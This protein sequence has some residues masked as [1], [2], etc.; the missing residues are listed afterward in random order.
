M[1]RVNPS[2]KQKNKPFKGTNKSKKKAMIKAKP[3]RGRAGKNKP[4]H[5]TSKI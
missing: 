5:K 1:P 2:T 4:I 3:T